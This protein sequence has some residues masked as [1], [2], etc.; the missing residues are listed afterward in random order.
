MQSAPPRQQQSYPAI[1]R[2][3]SATYKLPPCLALRLGN[4]RFD[5]LDLAGPETSDCALVL[6]AREVGAYGALEVG[7]G[8]ARRG[9]A[10]AGGRGG[11]GHVFNCR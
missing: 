11:G 8:G 5:A 3:I 1:S 6:G 9:T 4:T 7:D 2:E 10:L